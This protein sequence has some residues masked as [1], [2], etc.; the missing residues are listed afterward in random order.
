MELQDKD[1]IYQNN[2]AILSMSRV[3]EESGRRTMQFN[4]P[5]QMINSQ[6]C[7]F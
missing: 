5:S 6:V 3:D 4:P 7:Y 2:I 1:N